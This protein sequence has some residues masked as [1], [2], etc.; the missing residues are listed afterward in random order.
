MARGGTFMLNVGPDGKGDIP[1]Y[2]AES[3]R[4]SGKWVAEY[5]QVIYGAGAS[6]MEC[7]L[8]MGAMS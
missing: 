1:E 5:P 7:Q 3:L 4:K 8:S 6:A 2:A